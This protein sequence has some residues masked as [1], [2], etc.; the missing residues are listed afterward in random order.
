[1]TQKDPLVTNRIELNGQSGGGIYNSDGTTIIDKDGNID[2]PVT[3]T[4]LTLSG[5]LTV[6]GVSQLNSTLTVGVDDTG[7]DVK[8][9]GATA[10]AYCLWDESADDL[11][12]AGAAG[13][14]VAGVTTLTG[15]VTFGLNGGAASASGLL[16]GVGTTANPATSAAAGAIFMEFRTQN[17]AASGDSRGLYWRHDISGAGGGGEA[18]RAFAKITAAATTCRGAHVSLDLAAAGSVSG[19]G[20]GVDAQVLYGD[21]AYTNTATALNAE[22]YAAGSSSSISSGSGSFLRCVLGGDATGIA[23]FDDNASLIVIT[24]GSIASG[25][26]VQAETDETKFSHKIR[27]TFNGTTM[28]LMATES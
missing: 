3:S 8:F 11:I 12:L 17:S 19:F 5:T 9:F 23:D 15:K 7:Y 21:A 1:M 2:A 25:N 28:Y 4:N 6:A 10:S 27:C 14:S 24:G 18:L 22:L 16:A 20:A 13:L 26:I